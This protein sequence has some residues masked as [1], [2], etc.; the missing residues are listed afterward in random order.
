MLSVRLERWLDQPRVA[1]RLTVM[2]FLLCLPSLVIGRQADDYELGSQVRADALGAYRFAPLSVAQTRVQLHALRD[3]GRLPWWVNPDHHQAFYRPLAS[4]THWL[5][6]RLWPRVPWCMHLE[7]ALLYALL[8]WLAL[9]TQHGVGLRGRALAL[10]GFCYACNPLQSMSAGWLAGRNTVLQAVFG[11]LCLLL[12][13]RARSTG[14]LRVALLAMLA[15]CAALLSGEGGIACLGFLFAHAL[16][17]DT[18]GIG[19]R[20]AALTPYLLISAL[21]RSYYTSHGYGVVGSGFYRDLGGHPFELVPAMASVLPLYLASQLTLPFANLSL[22]FPHSL[23]F[24]IVV[25]VCLLALLSPL[26]WPLLRRDATARF[27]ALGALFSALPLAAALPGDRLVFFVGFGTTGLLGQLLANRL[28]APGRVGRWWLRQLWRWHALYAP[29]LFVVGLFSCMAT[30]LGGGASALE[31]AVPQAEE[32]VVV[33]LN[34]PSCL[35]PHFVN[36]MRAY[37]GRPNPH[38]IALY[39]GNADV[40]VTRQDPRSLELFVARGWLATPIERL[41]RDPRHAPFAVGQTLS[42]RD[43]QVSVRAVNADGAPTRVQFRFQHALDSAR[44]RLL[45]WR[46]KAPVPWTPPAI[47]EV[48]ML[49]AV[50]P[51]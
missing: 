43:V 44:L 14:S 29:V 6:F 39:A 32:P 50:R 21:W 5:D 26:L 41:L 24:C 4:L 15:F 33:L 25:S 12:Y 31:R 11:L 37:A 36:H 38:V 49:Q 7:N 8:I 51:I 42:L 35:L 30:L 10:A 40:S 22:L 27:H 3:D 23:S 9:A 45:I 1:L 18:S 34:S 2:A 28:D 47:G 16:T 19:R 46:D 48:A 20:V 13:D 17:R